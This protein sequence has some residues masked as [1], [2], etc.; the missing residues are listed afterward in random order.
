M[1]EERH[2]KLDLTKTYRKNFGIRIFVMFCVFIFLVSTVF[3]V[4]LVRNQ[5][6]SMTDNLIK[7]GRLLAGI[8]AHNAKIGVFSENGDLLRNSVEGA[9]QQEEVQQVTIFNSI[10]APL[11]QKGR[12]GIEDKEKFV[13]KSEKELQELFRS[14]GASHSSHFTEHASHFV[15]WSP[16]LSNSSYSSEEALFFKNP[17]LRTNVNTIGFVKIVVDRTALNDKINTLLLKSTLLGL[18]FLMIGSVVAFA[19]IKG[20]TKPLNRLTQNVRTLGEEGKVENVPVDTEDEIGRLATAFNDMSQSLR[21]REEEKE[22]LEGQLRHAQKMEAIGTLAGGI[23]HDFNN[24]LAGIMGYV[25]LA[26]MDTPPGTPMELNLKETMKASRRAADMVRQ[27][28]TFSRQEENEQHPV[29]MELIVMEA[30][31]ILRASLPTTIEIRKKI[32]PGLPPVLS[33]PTQIHQVL[34]NLCTNSAFV[35]RESGGLLEVSLAGAIIDADTAAQH[36]DLALGQYV[37]L[38]VSDTGCGMEKALIDRIFEPYFTTKEPDQGTGMGL[39]VVHGIVKSH[40]GAIFVHSELG[41][42]T[43]FQVFFPTGKGDLMR[44]CGFEGCHTVHLFGTISCEFT[45][46]GLGNDF[47]GVFIWHGFQIP[48]FFLFRMFSV[49]FFYDFIGNVDRAWRIKNA[50]FVHNQEVS[51]RFP[52]LLYDRQ[53]LRLNPGHQFSLYVL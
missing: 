29:H 21:D 17:S 3:T 48:L 44:A 19:L 52:N 1:T 20:I 14:L 38:V 42:G 32:E 26:L 2:V 49:E 9:L 6:S 46:D 25:E 11:I 5:S 51:S 35:M 43:T 45:K 31:K 7:K 22:R 27:I 13:H 30:L 50:P 36:P 12:H 16:V 8:L 40:K 39:A 15:F 10:G 18:I 34:M 33:D 47:Q 37:R 41:K 24:I 4:L 23:A 53:S 28:L